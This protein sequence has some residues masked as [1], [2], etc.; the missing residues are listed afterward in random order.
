[1]CSFMPGHRVPGTVES[2]GPKAEGRVMSILLIAWAD[3]DRRII[4]GKLGSEQ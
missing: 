3:G 4:G 2:L 1:M